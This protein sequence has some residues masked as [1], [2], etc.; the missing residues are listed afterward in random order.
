MRDVTESVIEWI[1]ENS[2]KGG[3]QGRE[4]RDDTDLLEGGVMDSV[5]LMNL[6][7]YLEDGYGFSLNPEDLTPENFRTP[8]IIAELV[9]R[10]I[11]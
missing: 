4:V 5:D 9:A 8:K 2:S 10:S 7:S 3:M 11:G 6:V 1:I